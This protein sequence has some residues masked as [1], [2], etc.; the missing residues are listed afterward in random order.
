VTTVTTLIIALVL[1]T[2]LFMWSATKTCSLR[3][4]RPQAELPTQLIGP[5][6]QVYARLVHALDEQ[7]GVRQ[8]ARDGTATLFSVLPVPSSMDRGFGLIVVVSRRADG[9]MLQAQR[10]IPLPAPHLPSALRQLER[11]ARRRAVGVT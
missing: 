8:L 11:E 5:S 1:A 9:V 6:D 2:A 10:R 7:P 3:H 4:F